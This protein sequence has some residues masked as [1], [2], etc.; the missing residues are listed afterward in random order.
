MNLLRRGAY[1][2]RIQEVEHSS[3][4]PL[5]RSS[6]G[7]FIRSPVALKPSFLFKHTYLH[8]VY[9]ISVL[10]LFLSFKM[11]NAAFSIA[12]NFN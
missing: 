6:C 8:S 7:H 3:F 12:P 9:V 4:T 1:E 5:V 2:L 10:L 11:V